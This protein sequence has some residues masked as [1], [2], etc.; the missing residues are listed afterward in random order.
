[1]QI[2]QSYP[3]LSKIISQVPKIYLEFRGFLRFSK[4]TGD[5]QKEKEKKIEVA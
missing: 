1:M 5:K 2:F 3:K 4:S